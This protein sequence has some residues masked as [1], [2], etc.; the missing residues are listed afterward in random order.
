M[1]RKKREPRVDGGSRGK[2]EFCLRNLAIESAFVDARGNLWR[3]SGEI[4]FVVGRTHRMLS[5][6]RIQTRLW[7]AQVPD[8]P[9]RQ[10]P[11]NSHKRRLLR[12]RI[13]RRESCTTIKRNRKKIGR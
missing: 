6:S 11:C 9:A 10:G 3:R 1:L 5:S 13:R 7:G 2:M 4:C 12:T 8:S